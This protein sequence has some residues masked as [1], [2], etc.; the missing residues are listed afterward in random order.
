[1]KKEENN[2]DFTSIFYK[3]LSYWPFFILSVG[4]CFTI[5]KVHLHFAIPVYKAATTIL[6][7]INK[8]VGLEEMSL[9]S[10][11]KSIGN[12]MALIE[13]YDMVDKTISK[14]DFDISYHHI[15]DVN[16]IE[17][18]HDTQFR[19]KLDSGE[20]H[21]FSRIYIDFETPT[22]FKLRIGEKNVINEIFTINKPIHKHGF[23]FTVVADSNA[24]Y[25]HPDYQVY[26]IINKREYLVHQYAR[27]LKILRAG[28][29]AP[30]ILELSMTGLVPQKIILFLNEHAQTYIQNGVD[31]KNATAINTI[32]FID[33]QLEQVSFSLNSAETDLESFRKIHKV[34][35]ISASAEI[36]KDN[37]DELEKE[38]SMEQLKSKYYDY[39]YTYLKQDK[40]L[41]EVIAPHVMGIDDP[42]LTGLIGELSAL[43]N[44][45]NIITRSSTP[46]NPYLKELDGKIYHTKQSVL[47]NIRNIISTAKITL[48]DINQRI[49]KYEQQLSFLPK[50]ERT[51]VDIQR[52]FNLNDNIYNYLLQK[53]AEAGIAKA[54]TIA[55]CKIVNTAKSFNVSPISPNG[56]LI[57]SL[58]LLI[59]FMIPIGF[60]VAR[61]L[62]ND[63]IMTRDDVV[64]NTDIP[65]LGIIG[66]N[67]HED[68]TLTVV[69]KPKS[70]IAE[71]FRSIRIN[72]QYLSADRPHKVVLI[73]SSIS[74]EGKSFFSANFACIMASL[75]K[76]TLLIGADLRKPKVF[77]E[78][79]VNNQIGLSTYLINNAT[80]NE[81]IFKSSVE[82]LDVLPAGPI[83]PN[84]SEL[85]SGNRIEEL[86]KILDNEYDYI[87]IDT[88]PIG[89]IADGFILMKYSHINLYIIRHAITQKKWLEKI[90]ILYE[91]KKIDNLAI[92]VNDL[93]ESGPY[94]YGYGYGYGYGYY[95]GDD[96][97][98]K[99]NRFKEFWNDV[100]GRYKSKNTL[101][102]LNL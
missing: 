90:N 78:L 44:E 37:L 43:N 85:L 99:V 48:N 76:K 36:L 47:E 51:L 35:D 59:G 1:M 11:S 86:F 87:I 60:I 34:M 72:L 20:Q 41:N 5:A 27:A 84:P 50:N 22:T 30:G 82:N 80:L 58:A 91:E 77:S 49:A 52:R 96:K 102:K 100:H 4:L 88:P 74:G 65:I 42:L 55:A 21:Y 32:K 73:T 57:T 13:A 18:Y 68:T 53:R 2:I 67:M 9:F 25:F 81:V 93:K 66:H 56:N 92:V 97:K 95:E 69:N 71:A 54:S 23:N 94:D 89:L 61:E 38:R 26:F 75:G 45:R 40:D 101:K 16:D 31:E 70:A 83:P 10:E 64:T 17:L 39:L 79:G 33:D 62:L 3:V 14:L 46:K 7:D 12:E 29:E 24:T 15:G 98:K 19:I 6:I 63:K 28:K 8:P